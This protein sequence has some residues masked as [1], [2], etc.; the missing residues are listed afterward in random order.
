[1]DENKGADSGTEQT[2]DQGGTANVS[3]D[4]GVAADESTKGEEP[5]V[6]S[7]TVDP[8]TVLETLELD[9]KVKE[10]LRNG[11]LRM[12]DYTKKTQ[13]IAEIRKNAE[14]FARYKPYIDKVLQ[15]ENLYQAVFGQPQTGQATGENAPEVP[16]D[17]VEFADWI[18]QRVIEAVDARDAQGADYAA[19]ERLDPRL[20]SDPEFAKLIGGLVAQDV[21]FLEGR[22][23]GEQAT[24]EAIESYNGY[25]AKM[26]EGF[27]KDMQ[28]KVTQKRMVIPGSGSPGETASAKA[29]TMKEAAQAAEEELSGK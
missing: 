15:D 22:K 28:T 25:V 8:I 5:V 24:H 1:M 3:Q 16:D 7:Q 14:E 23:S 6:T 9:P 11:F 26:R 17:P 10:E 18:Q 19:A 21:D 27:R 29:M 20:S 4:T 12:A 13:E 2:D